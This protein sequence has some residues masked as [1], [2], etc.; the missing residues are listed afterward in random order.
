MPYWGRKAFSESSFEQFGGLYTISI[1]LIITGFLNILLIHVDAGEELLE[2]D[3][4]TPRNSPTVLGEIA[5][6]ESENTESAVADHGLEEPEMA[7]WL[8]DDESE[9]VKEVDTN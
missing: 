7:D 2:I 8:E 1:L 3:T 9:E 4:P 6:M 5:P